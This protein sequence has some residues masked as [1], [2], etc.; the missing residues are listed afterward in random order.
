[1]T[2]GMPRAVSQLR[3]LSASWP[4]PV[5]C[6]ARQWM[7]EPEWDTAR[8][9]AL[10]PIADWTIDGANCLVLRWREA[11][12][13][14]KEFHLVFR[15]RVEATGRLVFWDDDGC[16]IRRD[17]EIVHQDR[18]VH[19]LERHELAVRAGDLLEIA[20]WQYHGDWLWAGRIE[21]APSSIDDDVAFFDRF[22][23]HITRAQAEPNGP[24]LKTYFAA[25]HPVRAALAIHS[26]ILN[27]YRPAG[28]KIY[29]D[30]QWDGDQRHAIERLL[31]FAEI[32]RTSQLNAT[33]GRFDE[34]LPSLARETWPAMKIC[35][36]LFDPPDE[37]CFLDDDVFVIGSCDDAVALF[38]DHDLVH[39]TDFDHGEH[40]RR[41]W[42]FR[43]GPLRT[44]TINTGICFVRNR[45]DL[46]GQVI[47]L[48]EN[49]PNG[50]P[51]WL[52]EQG[53][54]ATE[55]AHA[56]VAALPSQRYFY[57]VVDGLPGGILGYDWVENPCGF[58]TVHFGGLR[59][60]PTDDE[61]R[62]LAR[63]ILC[64][65]LASAPREITA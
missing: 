17:G 7:S 34:R 12:G 32:V 36:S 39:Q 44:G 53:F 18:Q 5:V 33:L 47:R 40:Y 22:R 19:A 1:M 16:I 64:R 35:V 54:M 49:P 52:W 46:D 21:P 23:C 11:F 37:Y 4:R 31:P 56:P 43:H 57:P 3:V 20:Q 14:M 58:A 48:L 63:S 6:R 55:F 65:H 9:P 62:I 2:E 61:V 45:G 24:V 26:L 60:K 38:R 25:T 27:G 30:Y 59:S 41:I 15:I 10:P 28:V 29:G 8:M 51:A 50:H 42:G 13:E